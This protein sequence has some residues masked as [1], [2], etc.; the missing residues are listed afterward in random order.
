LKLKTVID[1]LKQRAFAAWPPPAYDFA[2]QNRGEKSNYAFPDIILLR[3][4]SR[5]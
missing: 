2:L 1:W 3:F 4:D 5:L